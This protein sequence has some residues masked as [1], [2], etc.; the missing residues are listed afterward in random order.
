MRFP[1]ERDFR[2][3]RPPG[4][5]AAKTLARDDIKPNH[6]MVRLDVIRL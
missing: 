5:C 1:F 3:L 4:Q 6:K 2:G